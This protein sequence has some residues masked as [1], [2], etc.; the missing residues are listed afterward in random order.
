[1]RVDVVVEL[2]E[3]F[4]VIRDYL[5]SGGCFVRVG[6][7]VIKTNISIIEEVELIFRESGYLNYEVCLLLFLYI[8]LL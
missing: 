6:E 8:T 1:M 7:V 3:L 5:V 4:L 2:S